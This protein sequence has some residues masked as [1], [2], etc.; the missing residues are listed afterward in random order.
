M[1]NK[2][3]VKTPMIK[4]LFGAAIVVAC[5]S[6]NAD[7]HTG[8]SGLILKSGALGV[9]SLAPPPLNVVGA[10]LIKGIFGL[11]S[12]DPLSEVNSAL[13]DIQGSLD[14][15]E[16]TLSTLRED[17]VSDVAALFVQNNSDSIVAAI[18]NVVVQIKTNYHN[19]KNISLKDQS[20]T[21]FELFDMLDIHATELSTAINWFIYDNDIG[22]PEKIATAGQF[23]GM[24]ELH[25][26]ILQEQIEILKNKDFV[27]DDT[28]RIGKLES[29]INTFI[30]TIGYYIE[31]IESIAPASVAYRI[32]Q[33]DPFKYIKTYDTYC[34]Y[35]HRHRSNPSS[36]CHEYKTDTYYE[37]RIIDPPIFD[38]DFDLSGT[39]ISI[40]GVIMSTN[41]SLD[42]QYD[43]Y[44][45]QYNDYVDSVRI[46]TEKDVKAIIS[47]IVESLK[48]AQN[49]YR[50]VDGA[51]AQNCAVFH[52]KSDFSGTSQVYC[53]DIKVDGLSDQFK[54]SFSSVNV[55]SES[56]L[57]LYTENQQ[58]GIELKDITNSKFN[59]G[60]YGLD[61][62]IESFTLTSAND[63]GSNRYGERPDCGVLYEGEKLYPG[64]EL[65]S[66]NGDYVLKHKN[67]GN[68]V[69]YWQGN[70]IW[71][72][73]T[74]GE[75]TSFLKMKK[76]GQ[77]VL[78]NDG[79]AIWKSG[80]NNNNILV[81]YLLLS[82]DGNLA[83][84]NNTSKTWESGSYSWS[85]FQ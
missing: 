25:L 5:T 4:I 1:S 85:F 8:T 9:A 81:D 33:I 78:I 57:S 72:T 65:Y 40:T 71:K 36:E 53:D 28:K 52:K 76:N 73:K 19:D 59:L 46:Q 42:Q 32:S 44:E 80:S 31:F 75:T 18:N 82:D 14:S 37:Y 27:G 61:N 34:I 51:I 20:I 2:K 58:L 50:Y 67:N 22:N 30:D 13:S 39:D 45:A 23:I 64:D 7:V 68:V 3:S 74:A 48:I 69:I 10:E 41:P 21:S 38:F 26:M 47:P 16:N 79:K 54:N 49:Q 83:T 35:S 77:L 43:Y 6:T 60:E 15:I 24:A 84:I 55:G 11:G 56:T 70:A 62:D 12:E 63:T 17:I 66:C 29:T